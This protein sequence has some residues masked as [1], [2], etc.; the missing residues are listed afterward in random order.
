MERNIKVGDIL[1]GADIEPF[2]GYKVYEVEIKNLNLT[3]EEKKCGWNVECE[4][5]SDDEENGAKLMTN[6][7]FI[8]DTRKE[9]LEYVIKELKEN[10]ENIEEDLTNAQLELK[11]ENERLAKIE[12][13]KK[14]V[15][16]FKEDILAFRKV[17]NA[18]CDKDIFAHLYKISR[19]CPNFERA[20]NILR[21]AC[22]ETIEEHNEGI[23]RLL[24]KLF[25]FDKEET[26]ETEEE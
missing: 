20:L 17:L 15:A 23:D 14:K 18:V 8:Y 1:F 5:L 25:R 7:I 3:E 13:V 12:E 24:K 6:T 21:A 11:I 4:V 22:L 16:V 26:E 2:G 19:R 9:A 10:K